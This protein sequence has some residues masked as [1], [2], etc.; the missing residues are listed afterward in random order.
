VG[1]TSDCR[2]RRGRVGERRAAMSARWALIRIDE[3]KGENARDPA[4]GLLPA[5]PPAQSRSS[6]QHFCN[7]NVKMEPITPR[8][9]VVVVDC[10]PRVGAQI[11]QDC[12][13]LADIEVITDF[14]VAKRRILQRADPL[15]VTNLRLNEYNGLHLVYLISSAWRSQMRCVVYSAFP[16][17]RLIEEAQAAGALYEPASTLAYALPAYISSPLPERD[18][19]SPLS[20]D[21]R[22]VCRGGRRAPDVALLA[23]AGTRPLG[24]YGPSN[25]RDVV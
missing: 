23:I 20:S 2:A 1:A 4:L 16:D 19:R 9:R 7:R 14:P 5:R 13:A 25:R 12:A 6:W 10:D 17:L 3:N 15:L 18:R 22:R 24:E 8:K 11:R 21:R